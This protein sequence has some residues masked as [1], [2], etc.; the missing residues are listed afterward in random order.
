MRRILLYLFA[1]CAVS[2]AAQTTPVGFGNAQ[3][4][5][6]EEVITI[7]VEQLKP[8]SS[9]LKERKA[10]KAEAG[11]KRFFMEAYKKSNKLLY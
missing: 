4:F 7:E 11:R 1:A 5:T 6:D 3:R 9:T 8:E 10:A 2:L